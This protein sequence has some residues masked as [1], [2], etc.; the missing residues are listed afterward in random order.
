MVQL[1]SKN[2]TQLLLVLKIMHPNN[3]FKFILTAWEIFKRKSQALAKVYN[4][5]QHLDQTWELQLVIIILNLLEEESN[6]G[7][8]LYYCKERVP[9]IRQNNKWTTIN[10]QCIKFPQNSNHQK[11]FSNVQVIFNFNSIRVDRIFKGKKLVKLQMIQKPSL[12]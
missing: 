5:H 3:K 8:F 7:D 9:S 6:Q 10:I 11:I 1:E 12:D 4:Q 2:L